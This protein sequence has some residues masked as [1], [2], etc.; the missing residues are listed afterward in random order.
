MAIGELLG[1][2]RTVPIVAITGGRVLPVEGQPFEDGV[3]LI[4]D[5]KIVEL[6]RDVRV[7]DGAERID[8]AGKV[9]T[10]GLMDAHAHVGVWEEAEGWAGDDVNEMTDPNTAH[11]RAVDAI[12]P[13]EEGFRD[14]IRGGVLAVNVNPGSGNP[15]GGQTVALK[16]WGRTVDR[17][18]LRQPSGLKSA[19]G[20]NPKRVY[21]QMRGDRKMPST[22]L[23][24]AA[25]IREAFVSAANYSR[26]PS[27]SAASRTKRSAGSSAARS[28]GASTATAPMTSPP[29]C[30]SP[31]SS[32]TAWSSTTA[33]RP[34]CWPTSWPSAASRL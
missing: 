19:L 5:G 34:T 14:A 21:G 29:P 4:Q 6:G 31:T 33:P 25:V 27:R 9:V 3:I 11:V 24:T 10:P 20:E 18:V 16:T 15:I 28:P 2:V 7:P 12:N 30:G 23:G 13:A 1:G 17:M 32:A 8:A 26:R 22:R